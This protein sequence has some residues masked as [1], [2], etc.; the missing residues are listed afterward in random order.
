MR[1]YNLLI[2]CSFYA[3]LQIPFWTFGQDTFSI[4]AVDSVTGQVGSAGATCITSASTS[5]III[6][7]VHPGVGVIH[8][9]AS[10]LS[11]NQNY[12]RILM[13]SGYTPARIIDSLIANDV[14]NN[15]LVRQYG[16]VDLVNGVHSAA[17]TGSNC[18]SY[19]NHI[20][21]VNYSIQGNILLGQ[22]ILDSMQSRFVNTPGSLACKLMAALQGAKVIGADTRCAPYGIS[23]YSAFVRVAEPA[24]TTGPLYLDLTVN[25]FPG[26]HDPIDS[27]QVMFDNWGGCSQTYVQSENKKLRARIFPNPAYNTVKVELNAPAIEVIFYN[28]HGEEEM[29]TTNRNFA[30]YTVNVSELKKG[31]YFI[32]ICFTDGEIINSRIVVN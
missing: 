12:A 4:C 25:T 32:K 1:K 24:D 21:G 23:T 17:Y 26:N 10:Y 9:Q 27:L 19:K 7:D 5:A 11:A 22:E 15:P 20:A 29:K 8:T 13:D 31:M 2:C 14:Q 28:I 30:E 3:I 16:I 18:S 6:S